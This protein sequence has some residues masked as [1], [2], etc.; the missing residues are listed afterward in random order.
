MARN[1]DG[2]IVVVTGGANGMGEREAHT[3][4]ELGAT[5]VIADRDA[6]RTP[7]VESEIHERGGD[8]WGVVMDL[9]DEDQVRR[10]VADVRERYGRVDVLDNNAA[11]LELTGRDLDVVSLGSEVFLES[12][13]SDLLP[14]FLMSKYTIPVMLEQGAGSIVNIASVSGMLGETTLTAYGIAKAGV[15]QL[16]RATATQYSKRGIRCN[17]VAPAYVSTPN[18]AKYAPPELGNIYERAM[19]TPTVVP[20][21]RVADVV[22]FL[23]SDEAQYVTGHVVP[24]DGG[25]VG[26]SPIVPDYRDW[27]Q[28]DH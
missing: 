23:A 15:I 26:A 9:R 2:K 7:L 16:T 19:S 5:V 10:L 8:A 20:M 4:A 18:N 11:A 3:F 21:Q 28:Q 12:L 25:L 17:A 24:V 14:A 27:Q 13:R 1:L 22:A 6:E